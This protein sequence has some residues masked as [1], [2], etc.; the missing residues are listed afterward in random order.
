[1]SARR[2]ADAS[3]LASVGATVSRRFLALELKQL[4][5]YAATSSLLR[6]GPISVSTSNPTTSTESTATTTEAAAVKATG[7]GSRQGDPVTQN[8][9]QVPYTTQTTTATAPSS[10]NYTTGTWIDNLFTSA[11]LPLKSTPTPSIS[12]TAGTPPPKVVAPEEPSLMDPSFLATPAAHGYWRPTVTTVTPPRPS[13]TREPTPLSKKATTAS[14]SSSSSSQEHIKKDEKANRDALETLLRE[15]KW[16]DSLPPEDVTKLNL[17]GQEDFWAQKQRLGPRMMIYE[18]LMDT[19]ENVFEDDDDEDKLY[20]HLQAEAAAAMPPSPSGLEKPIATTAAAAYQASSPTRTTSTLQRAV[21][22]S[23]PAVSKAPVSPVSPSP[24]SPTQSTPASTVSTENAAA[25]L[26]DPVARTTASETVTSD[27]SSDEA[28]H[29]KIVKKNL[30][31]AS[32]P[33]S[34]VSRLF[35]YG[36]L[37][38][39]LGVGAITETMRRSVGRGTVASESPTFLTPANMDR[40]VNKLTRMRGAALKLGQMLSIQ[41]NKMLPPELE[42]VLLRVQ[43]SANFMPEKQM[44]KVMTQT[45]GSNW[46]SE[47]TDFGIVPIAAASIGQVH[48]AI[49]RATGM[50]VAVKVQYPGVAASIDSDLS[51]LKTLVVMSNLLPRGM[52]LDNTIKVA[53]RELGW[54]TDYLREAEC[55]EEF[56]RLLKDDADYQVPRLVKEASGPMVLTMEWMNGDTM[57]DAMQMEDQAVRDRIGT[58]ILG[59][60]LREL[61]E[62]Q[63]MQT[64]PNWTNFLYN[65]ATQKLELLDFGATRGFDARFTSLY[66]KTILAGAAGDREACL[67]HSRELGFLTGD[68]TEVMETAH[69]NSLLT[70]S[71]PFQESAPDVYD[72]KYQTITQRVKDQI[73]TMLKYRLTPPPDETYSMHRKLAGAFLLCSKLG[74]RVECKKLF[75][76]MTSRY[77][78]ERVDERRGFDFGRGM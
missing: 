40:L 72:F 36:G 29:S 12:A 76:D 8:Q 42:E 75:R 48:K 32:M 58:K 33:T 71:E 60:S 31:A 59:L 43:N 26:H 23:S 70:L 63:Y 1:M 61:F 64:D 37:A 15:S 38:A 35:H 52:Y 5:A 53:Q 41:D 6:T 74:A 54:E 62:F 66:L 9:Q 68:E 49:H 13:S 14:S 17:G 47:F 65:H 27:S 51:N 21:Q 55:I 69:I 2:F 10:T 16:L 45:M 39:S 3:A 4:K 67:H 34:R 73:P 28:I 30:T 77:N 46:E 20:M 7:P 44:R 19:D 50:P 25:T 56:G 78:E 22:S 57:S 24:V 18:P 11:S